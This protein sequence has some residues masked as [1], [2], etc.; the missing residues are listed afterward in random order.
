MDAFVQAFRT[1]GYEP[2]AGADLEEG[3]EKVAIFA[4]N[5]VPTHASRQLPSGRWSSKLGVEQDIEHEVEG[6]VGTEY[7]DV[8]IL[9][10]RPVPA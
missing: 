10:K 1:L 8:G 6:L 3:F 5:G 7:G 4:L 2:C 9:L